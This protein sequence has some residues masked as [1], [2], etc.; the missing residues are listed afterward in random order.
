MLGNLKTVEHESDSRAITIGALGTV[1]KGLVKGVED[2]EKKRT[3]GDNPKY[4]ITKIGQ[5]TKK[6]LGDLKGLVASCS[7]GPK[8]VVSEKKEFAEKKHSKLEF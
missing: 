3:N 8:Y 6:S 5:N 2:L 4:S 1:T 7:I